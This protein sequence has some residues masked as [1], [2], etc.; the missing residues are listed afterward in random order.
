MISC[1]Q[2]IPAYSEGFKYLHKKEGKQEVVKFW[3]V[4]SDL[5]LTDSLKKE[6]KEKGIS[7]CFDYWQKALNEEAA[8]FTMTLD[9]DKNTF[10]IM[11]HHCPSKGMLNQLTYMSP[12][13]DYCEHC[14]LLYRRVLEPLGFIYTIDLSTCHKAVCRLVVTKKKLM[15]DKKNGRKK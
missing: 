5:Y 9:K 12:Y 7:G 6:V 15:E 3:E 10:E 11:M 14:D 13:E 8:D 4:L 1:T 2:F